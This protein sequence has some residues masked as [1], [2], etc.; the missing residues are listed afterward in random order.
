MT[1]LEKEIGQYHILAF[2]RVRGLGSVYSHHPDRCLWDICGK[3]C[4]EW[5]L[6]VVKGAKYIDKIAV[7]SE[8]KKILETVES[9]GGVVAIERQ[10]YTSH[11]VPRDYTKGIFKRNKPRSLLSSEPAVYGSAVN[12]LWYYLKETEGYEHD[13]FFEFGCNMPMITSEL[14]NRMI[15]KFFLDEGAAYVS[16]FFPIGTNVFTF[17]PVTGRPIALLVETGL[18]KQCA[19]PILGTAPCSF[20]GR[21]SKRLDGLN[22]NYVDISPE[23]GFDMHNEEDLFLARCYMKRR[24]LREGKKVEW[25][26]D[27]DY[28]HKKE[29]E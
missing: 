9:I 8:S 27:Q 7:A 13:L 24:L 1:E 3:P 19:P 15:E 12:Y 2:S 17:N 18:P 23:E 25:E 4:I 10:L 26:M 6:E 5:V 11:D 29:K 16:A 20:T 21:A 28:K 22:R 14:I